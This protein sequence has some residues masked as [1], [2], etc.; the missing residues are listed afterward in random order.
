MHFIRLE[1]LPS[2]PILFNVFIVKG[3]WILSNDF[4]ASIDMIMWLLSTILLIWCI[5]LIFMFNCIFILY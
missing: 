1:K 3:Y 2:I 4:S 5:T